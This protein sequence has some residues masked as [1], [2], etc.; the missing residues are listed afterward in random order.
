MS[1]AIERAKSP[2][3]FTVLGFSAMSLSDFHQTERFFASAK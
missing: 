2:A 3:F 1:K